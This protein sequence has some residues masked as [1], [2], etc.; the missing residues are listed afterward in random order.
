MVW[1][2][3]TDLWYGSA[4]QWNK[5]YN[6]AYNDFSAVVKCLWRLDVQHFEMA[7]KNFHLRVF[8]LKQSVLH[9]NIVNK[10]V[11]WTRTP[12]R[13]PAFVRPRLSGV[14][15]L[16]RLR[17]RLVSVFDSRG[18]AAGLRVCCARNPNK[19]RCTYFY[20]IEKLIEN[21]ARV[22]IARRHTFSPVKRVSEKWF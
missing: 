17:T 19:Y 14:Y 21:T 5:N 15:V 16:Y 3:R 18:D 8:F 6:E 20:Y 13:P 12:T 7:D 1:F 9:N 2:T 10:L 11:G 4:V 22:R